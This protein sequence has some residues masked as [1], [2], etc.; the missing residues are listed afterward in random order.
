M[1]K[2]RGGRKLWE[3][4]WFFVARDLFRFERGN[5]F[6]IF[7]FFVFLFEM[8]DLGP[9]GT[10]AL[11]RSS[12][13]T[14]VPRLG[15]VGGALLLAVAGGVTFFSADI[16]QARNQAAQQRQ[17]A[18]LLEKCEAS[19]A[20]SQL[21]GSVAASATPQEIEMF[22]R[23]LSS[24]PPATSPLPYPV[25]PSGELLFRKD[26]SIIP[27]GIPFGLVFRQFLGRM[28]SPI[29]QFEALTSRFSEK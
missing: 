27:A 7:D 6:V 9:V 22:S 17:S 10:K 14:I 19:I 3:T 29:D 24:L 26:G 4:A 18:E 5:F 2:M 23:V 12:L 21:A 1:E 13:L 28:A 16:E 20:L 15:L 8:A 25:D 11:G